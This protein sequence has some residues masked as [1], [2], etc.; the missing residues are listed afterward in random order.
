MELGSVVGFVLVLIGI[1]VG[2]IMKHVSPAFL[3]SIPAALLIVIVA[4]A[5][6]TMMSFN[7]ADTAGVIKAIMKSF[8]PGAPID[9]PKVVKVIVEFATKARR[10]GLLS[11]ESD[12]AKIEDPFLKKGLQMAIDGVDPDAVEA[13]LKT[14]VKA[15]K[16]RHKVGSAW[17]TA[18][19]IFAP[20]FGIIG[21][22][23]GL[24]AAMKMLADPNALAGGIAAA[25][26]ATFWGVF[27]ANGV[28]LPIGNKLKRM[29]EDEAQYR[30]MLTEAV[31]AIQAGQ[32]PRVVEE[33]LMCY[34]SPAEQAAAGKTS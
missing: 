7:F 5:G 25:F 16:A 29:S 6:A 9:K 10:D 24:I 12:L 26:V 30:E 27:L 11:L 31:L 2:A 33:T 1:F 15:M 32:N 20:T 8:L 14:D 34:L 28:M 4:S 13:V 23:F 21:A 19:G 17:C 3:V 18:M 22:V